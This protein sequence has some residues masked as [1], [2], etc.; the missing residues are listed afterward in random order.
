MPATLTKPERKLDPIASMQSAMLKQAEADLDQ[1]RQAVF[2]AAEG[3]DFDVNSVA[4]IMSR[5][6]WTDELWA[7]DV[8]AA[9]DDLSQRSFEATYEKTM[10]ELDQASANPATVEIKISLFSAIHRKLQGQGGSLLTIP[11][12]IMAALETYRSI[13]PQQQ[14]MFAQ[15]RILKSFHAFNRRLFSSDTAAAIADDKPAITIEQTSRMANMPGGFSRADE[16]PSPH[17]LARN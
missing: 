14:S 10:S 7:S 13:A 2:S 17:P 16:L 4:K 8:A 12:E 1:Y 11:R 9:R 15:M 6:S 5:H 3:H